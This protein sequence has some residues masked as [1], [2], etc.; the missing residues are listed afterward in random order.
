MT[1]ALGDGSDGLKM[2]FAFRNDSACR[3]RGIA[4]NE[5]GPLRCR[6]RRKRARF[7]EQGARG[8]RGV[9]DGQAEVFTRPGAGDR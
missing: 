5:I 1:E 3:G 4:L 9:F 2:I 6:H 8:N 7:F